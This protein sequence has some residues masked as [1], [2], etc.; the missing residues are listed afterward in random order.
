MDKADW[1]R[2]LIEQALEEIDDRY[3]PHGVF[4]QPYHNSEHANDVMSAAR[5]IG[6]A[7]AK[8]GKISAHD[9]PLLELAACYHDIIHD[10]PDRNEEASAKLLTARMKKTGVFSDRDIELCKGAIL[11]TRYHF[12]GDRFVQAVTDDYYAMVLADADLSSTGQEFAIYQDRSAKLAAENQKQL[13]AEDQIRFLL[14]HRFNTAEAKR[15]YPN[16]AANIKQLRS[17]KQ[18]VQK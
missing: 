3:G 10:L 17:L 5:A 9:V 15:L 8:A 18:V 14:G 12:E 4:L 11:A 13:D 1:I 6:L 2:K 16:K 7:A